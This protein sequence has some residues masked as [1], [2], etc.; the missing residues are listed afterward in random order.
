MTSPG[1]FKQLIDGMINRD[2]KLVQLDK[3]NLQR[4]QNGYDFGS[5][6]NNYVNYDE[7]KECTFYN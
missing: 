7:T 1:K 5:S 4:E 3:V 2:Q 6:K